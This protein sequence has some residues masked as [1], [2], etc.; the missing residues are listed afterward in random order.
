LP[1]I[2]DDLKNFS[3]KV[4]TEAAEMRQLAMRYASSI[5]IRVVFSL[6]GMNQN[7]PS[8]LINIVPT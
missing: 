5:T 2:Q 7:A 6:G 1:T 8:L 4:A 3:P